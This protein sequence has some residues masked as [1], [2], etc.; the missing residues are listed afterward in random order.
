M[1]QLS[2]I[3]QLQRRDSSS[4]ASLSRPHRGSAGAA[5]SSTPIIDCDHRIISRLTEIPHRTLPLRSRPGLSASAN[6]PGLGQRIPDRLG[7][8]VLYSLSPA[9]ADL[10]LCRVNVDVDLFERNIKKQKRDRIYAMRQDRTKTLEQS[11]GDR[12]V[13]DEALVNKKVLRIAVRPP[14]ARCRDET[15]DLC[16][17][18]PAAVDTGK[19][20]SSNPLR[21]PETTRSRRSLAGATR[22]TSRPLLVNVNAISG[23]ASA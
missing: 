22:S 1:S 20:L 8:N 7:N 2:G 14:F 12:L 5:N 17:K 10:G 16:D 19:R 23:C 4:S 15:R 13:A 6:D 11:A 3:R 21:I 18:F 9:K